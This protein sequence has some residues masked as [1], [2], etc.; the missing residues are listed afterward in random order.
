MFDARDTG[1]QTSV[2]RRRRPAALSFGPGM[3]LFDLYTWLPMTTAFRGAARLIWVSNFAVSV[4]AAFGVE[5]ILR[6]ARA[7]IAIV[8]SVLVGVVG[9]QLIM[10]DGLSTADWLVAALIIAAAA[11]AVRPPD[12]AGAIIYR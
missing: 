9:L 4:L 12:G 11:V 7:R 1:A 10:P 8:A 2:L 5:A 6:L 3:P